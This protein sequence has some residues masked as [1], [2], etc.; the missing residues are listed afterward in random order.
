MSIFYKAPLNKKWT[1]ASIKKTLKSLESQ[2]PSVVVET[3]SKEGLVEELDMGYLDDVNIH[4][5][6]EELDDEVRLMSY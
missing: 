4:V 3:I 6:D 2:C 5:Y 1:Q